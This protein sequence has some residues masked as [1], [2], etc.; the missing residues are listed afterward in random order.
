VRAIISAVLFMLLFLTGNTIMQ[1]VRERTGEFAVLKTLG[2]SDT[3]LLALVVAE[4]VTLCILAGLAGLLLV[5]AVVAFVGAHATGQV[6]MQISILE[7]N[8]TSMATGMVFAL[9][10]ALVASLIPA[11]RVK[12]LNVVDAL[13]GR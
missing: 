2:F 7:I 10:M 13:A 11:L 5:K 8:W 4:A 3:G 9:G 1:S 12:R 6:T